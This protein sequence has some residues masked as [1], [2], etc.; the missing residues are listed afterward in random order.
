MP[1][2]PCG[3]IR[4]QPDLPPLPADRFY[5]GVKKKRGP[6]RKPLTKI[7]RKP[8]K[9]AENPYRSYTVSYKLRVLSYWIGTRIRCSPTKVRELTQEEV[10]AYFKVPASNL[11]RWRIE[12]KE[13]KFK[14]QK[15]GQRRAAG[16]GRKRCWP[17]MEKEL[18]QQF[19]ERR[20]LGRPVRWGWFKRVSKDLFKKH[21]PARNPEEFRFSNGWFRG[22]LNWH[23][24]SLRFATNK[25]SQLPKD[26]GDAILSWLK[27]NCRNSQYRPGETRE[28]SWG[29]T[30]WVGRYQLQNICNMDQTPLPFEYLVTVFADG[31]PRVKPLIFF[32]GMGTGPTIVAE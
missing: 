2:A 13:G 28:A 20:A 11:S 15:A 7:L 12:E 31:I 1:A 25:A 9:A 18:F 32:R 29:E 14:Q 22:Y 24:I 27:F 17:E 30:N 26:F 16:G 21:Y 23:Q 10:A 19:R 5:A 4:V 3:R 6:K 8:K